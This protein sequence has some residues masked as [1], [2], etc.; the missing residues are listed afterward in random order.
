MAN[1]NKALKSPQWGPA[2]RI[3][4][5]AATFDVLPG[6]VEEDAA[7]GEGEEEEG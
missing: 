7:W 1:H 3:P 5:L 2:N 4:P 6:E